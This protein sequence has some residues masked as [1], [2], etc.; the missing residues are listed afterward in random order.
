MDVPKL[1]DPDESIDSDSSIESH[2][3]EPARIQENVAF[4]QVLLGDK[5][6]VELKEAGQHAMEIEELL[7][8]AMS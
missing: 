4:L 1:V 6:K 5:V 7:E 3:Q 8:L 2:E